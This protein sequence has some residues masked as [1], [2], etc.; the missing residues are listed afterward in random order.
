MKKRNVIVLMVVA[1]LFVGCNTFRL[2]DTPEFTATRGVDLREYADQGFLI[3]PET[4]NG[5]YITKG[6]IEVALYPRV[7]Y[8]T[9]RYPS[10]EDYTARF[11]YDDRGQLYT[12]MVEVVS[13]ETAIR[14]MHQIAVEWGADAI[15][16]FEIDRGTTT[17]DLDPRTAY[18]YIL[19]SGLVIKRED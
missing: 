18:Q 7:T 15:I 3:T 9:G 14:R 17:T 5:K 11:I 10:G 13:F 4:Y 1:M 6:M 8:R 12:Q 16:R 19:V 2:S